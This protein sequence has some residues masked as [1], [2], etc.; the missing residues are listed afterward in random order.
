MNRRAPS[1]PL[2]SVVIP[3]RDEERGIVAALERLSS[4]SDTEILV[5][6]DELSRDA[7]AERASMVPDVRVLPSAGVGRGAALSAGARAAH[8]RYLLFLHADSRIQEAAVRNALGVLDGENLAA[9][10]SIR[11]DSP[12]RVFRVLEAGI[13]LRSRL[14]DLPYGDQG[15]LISKNAY[16]EAGGF[17]PLARCE[18]LDLVLRLRACGRIALVP[19]PCVTST[20]RWDREGVLSVTA[21]NLSTLARFLIA[22]TTRKGATPYVQD[23]APARFVPRNDSPSLDESSVHGS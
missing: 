7:S 23:S 1:A 20:R 12:R 9:A 17:R 10:F 5:A 21:S 8:G 22:S 6:V 14:F 2:L 18:D 13:N 4:W 19:G 16:D 15:L 3:V 11:L